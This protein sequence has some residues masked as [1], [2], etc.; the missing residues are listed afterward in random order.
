VLGLR[1][2]GAAE[3]PLD[4]TQ[5]AADM[6]HELPDGVRLTDVMRGG[7]FRREPIRELLERRAVPGIARPGALQL[8]RNTRRLTHLSSLGVPAARRKRRASWSIRS[9][10][11][12]I[13]SSTSWF[14]SFRRAGSPQKYPV[15]SS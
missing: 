9:S 1:R 8:L 7:L 5:P 11:R 6:E 2:V 10:S 4:L 3:P 13:A 12:S 15:A 14:I